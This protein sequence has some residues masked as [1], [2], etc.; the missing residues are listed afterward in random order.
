M[1][2]E[3]ACLSYSLS[4]CGEYLVAVTGKIVFV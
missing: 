4:T 2:E 1:V 3:F